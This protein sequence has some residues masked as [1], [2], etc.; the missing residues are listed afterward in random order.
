M[1]LSYKNIYN[2]EGFFSEDMDF[3]KGQKIVNN[4]DYQTLFNHYRYRLENS[5][6]DG[7]KIRVENEYYERKFDLANNSF[8]TVQW[9]IQALKEVIKNSKMEL[10]PV[11]VPGAYETVDLKN[12]SK[13]RLAFAANNK[14]PVIVA[15][16]PFTTITAII[17][18]GNHRIVA[19]HK[20]NIKTID[21]YLLAPGHFIQAITSGY[22]QMLTA[23]H[24]N[25]WLIDHY[26]TGKCDQKAFE[27]NLFKV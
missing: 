1:A 10:R 6:F 8:Y 5:V 27:S 16:L 3:M 7:F 25:L 26:M 22:M 21:G 12:I 2:L 4:F 18:D 14:E 11:W 20:K 13:E 15:A 24:Y 23:I 19:N 9:S 17:L